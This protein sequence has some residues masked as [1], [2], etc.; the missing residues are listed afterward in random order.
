MYHCPIGAIKSVAV[1]A[2][3]RYFASGSYD[4]SVRVWR[5]R[6]AAL[7]HELTGNTLINNNIIEVS[8]ISFWIHIYSYT[9]LILSKLAKGL[10]CLL[11][12]PKW[13]GLSYQ[14]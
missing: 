7:M 5:T 2:D 12:P 14:R 13:T 3:S 9:F 4:K 10:V 11:S 6:D 1:S 8:R